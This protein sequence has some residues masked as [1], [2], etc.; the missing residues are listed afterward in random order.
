MLLTELAVGDHRRRVWGE[1]KFSSSQ[2]LR[3]KASEGKMPSRQPPGR[4]RYKARL[5]L[6]KQG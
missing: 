6:A 5:E 3:L 1:E 2:P 4:R